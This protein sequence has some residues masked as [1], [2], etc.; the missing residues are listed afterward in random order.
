MSALTTTDSQLKEG[1]KQTEI[2]IIPNDWSIVTLGEV[3]S[4]Q[5]GVNAD[6]KA[7]GTGIPFINISE[8]IANSFLTVDKI[9]G[10]VSLSS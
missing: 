2:G 1:Y 8:V 9:P 4:F 6:K 3:L 5:N 10:R 7:Y